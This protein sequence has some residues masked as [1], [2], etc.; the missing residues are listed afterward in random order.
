[1]TNTTGRKTS[2]LDRQFD[3]IRRREEAG[4][5]T[6]PR[7]YRFARK[8]LSNRLAAIGLLIFT[9]IVL[10]SVLAPLLTPYDPRAIDLR[11][12]L[13]PPTWAH[14]FGTDKVGRDLLTRVLYGGQISILVGLGSALASAVVGVLIGCYT[15]Y[16]GGWR[17]ALAMRVSEI[18]MSFPQIILVLLL[19][20]IL[21]QSLSNLI[22]IFILTGWGG[23]YR[24]A[25]ARM[26]SL[27]EEEYVQALRSFGL[28]TPIICYKHILP[29]ALGPI[30]VNI[31]LSTAA[32]ILAEAGL[33]FLG[34]GVPLDIPTW[35]N[36]LNVAQDLRILENNWWV[37]LPV[38]I[39]ISLF[40]LSVNFIGDGLRDATDPTQQG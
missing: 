36:I 11:N 1:M 21:G 19:V 3:L 27:R 15:G 39:V 20:A 12:I 6:N 16:V 40:V 13:K 14:W 31:T 34:L 30:M 17:D 9:I 8:F 10:V 5:L 2:R 7:G 23:I 29:N 4:Q 33:S 38:G 28:S 18:F 37:W 24:L 25:R 32:F 35:G 22:I 26:L